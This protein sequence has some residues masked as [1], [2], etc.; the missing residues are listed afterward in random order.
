MAT[1]SAEVGTTSKVDAHKTEEPRGAWAKEKTRTSKPATKP[2]DIDYVWYCKECG[3]GPHT[4][5]DPQCLMPY[6]QTMFSA[7][8]A[9]VEPVYWASTW[10][11]SHQCCRIRAL[12]QLTVASIGR[13]ASCLSAI[14]DEIVHIPSATTL[15]ATWRAIKSSRP[16][17]KHHT[18]RI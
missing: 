13:E 5:M 16:S 7:I 9:R 3:N 8:S 1:R 2:T 10:S 17:H 11:S 18:G 15:L 14:G 12:F 6:C 4:M